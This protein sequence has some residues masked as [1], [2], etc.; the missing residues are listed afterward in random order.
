MPRNI[1]I[2]KISFYLAILL[3]ALGIFTTYTPLVCMNI[4]E[5]TIRQLTQENQELKAVLQAYL[6]KYGPLS[7]NISQNEEIPTPVFLNDTTPNDTII[8]IK[9]AFIE[10]L[11]Q[12]SSTHDL[13][14]IIAMRIKELLQKAA[15]PMQ[16]LKGAQK[17]QNPQ[18]YVAISYILCLCI[19]KL[20]NDKKDASIKTTIKK[21]EETSYLTELPL[22]ANKEI[23][24]FQFLINSKKKA[25]AIQE[26]T[27][28][29]AHTGI[30]THVWTVEVNFMSDNPSL[31]FFKN[32]KA[33]N[34]F[35]SRTPK[36]D[37]LTI[38][39]HKINANITRLQAK[40]YNPEKITLLL[41]ELLE[42]TIQ[43]TK[44]FHKKNFKYLEKYF[45]ILLFYVYGFFPTN[46][47]EAEFTAG[48]GKLDLLV[49]RLK[50]PIII[51]I[52]NN[53]NADAA[54]NQINQKK[55][56]NMSG[57]QEMNALLIGINI[58]CDENT[59]HITLSSKSEDKNVTISPFK[60]TSPIQIKNLTPNE[61][62]FLTLF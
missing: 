57:V 44:G 19:E 49:N 58:T 18:L 46:T 3:L 52:K 21:L 26:A 23:Y 1:F 29:Q 61:S 51:E 37:Y 47:V 30:T 36:R 13:L 56:F 16:S 41:Q 33:P 60:K 25:C 34:H 54:L 22:Y 20:F 11:N 42:K 55:Y 9:P 12:A 6:E 39:L 17:N 50:N 5:E 38:P 48:E 28:L 2:K 4:N 62:S 32:D 40:I 45:H 31:S 8:E 15:K 59:K 35:L 43:K 24:I 53:N 7:Q 27:V 10:K 14:D